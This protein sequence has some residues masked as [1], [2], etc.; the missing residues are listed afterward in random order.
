[1]FWQQTTGPLPLGGL[2][3]VLVLL[4][5]LQSP[6][7]GASATAATPAGPLEA[8]DPVARSG[9]VRRLPLLPPSPRREIRLVRPAAAEVAD[10]ADTALARRDDD[11]AIFPLDFR[12][13]NQ[14][15]FSG[16]WAAGSE[17][18]S[19]QLDCVDCHTW[20]RIAAST[21]FPDDLDS[22]LGDLADPADLFTQSSLDVRFDG[23][24]ASI[25][26]GLTTA[27]SG[28][29]SLPL[30]TSESPIGISGPGFQVGVVFS[31]DLVLGITGQVEA[32][33]GFR[34]AIPDGSTFSMPLDDSKPNTANFDGASASLLPL[35]TSAP[36]ANVTLALRLRVQAGVQ[37]DAGLALDAQALAGAYLN[38]PEVVLFGSGDAL[39][40]GITGNITSSSSGG[41]GNSSSSLSSCSANDDSLLLGAEFN[42]NA[43]VFVDVG[44]DVAGV[45]LFDF[46]PAASTTLFAAVTTTCVGGSGGGVATTT[47]VSTTSLS[48]PGGVAAITTTITTIA[49]TTKATMTTFAAAAVAI[50]T[51]A[52]QEINCP[53]NLTAIIAGD[54]AATSSSAAS[55][56]AALASSSSSAAAAAEVVVTTTVCPGGGGASASAAAVGSSGS[57]S[58]SLSLSLSAAAP[59]YG[60][61][62]AAT[63]AAAAGPSSGTT[64]SLTRLPSPVTS[65]LTVDPAVTAPAITNL[66]AP[67]AAAAPPVVVIVVTSY[68]FTTVRPAD[69]ACSGSSSSSSTAAGSG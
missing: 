60:S 28:Q 18:L 58:P 34:V 35:V 8:R 40:T 54:A 25:D 55:S 64:V 52:V 19:L 68:A 27:A 65:T 17:T 5:L 49:T 15:L 14:K 62:A 12:L 44:A 11:E 7:P 42:I 29:F 50:T 10:A 61:G 63:A 16:S 43:G 2:I 39:A 66:T 69:C 24:G 45:D 53:T 13:T 46:N 32:N 36:A 47:T 20:G 59:A 67:A 37:L 1:M 38:I 4:A 22:L 26:L 30:F 57:G 48:C 56:S 33:G 51:C 31:I 21:T 9:P 6:V 3:L 41:S 23:V